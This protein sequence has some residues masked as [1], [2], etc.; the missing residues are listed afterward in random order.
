MKIAQQTYDINLERYENGD[1]TSM[2]LNLFQNQL[3][4]KKNSLIDAQINY[5]LLLLDMKVQTLW[6]FEKDQ[7]VDTDLLKKKTE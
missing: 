1:L 3:S 2:D 6:D 7:P 5:K 4:E